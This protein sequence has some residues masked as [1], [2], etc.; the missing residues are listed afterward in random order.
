MINTRKIKKAYRTGKVTR[1]IITALVITAT[2]ATTIIITNRILELT[3]GYRLVKVNMDATQT[4]A[5]GVVDDC[6]TKSGEVVRID[7][8]NPLA[9]PDDWCI[10]GRGQTPLDLVNYK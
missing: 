3:A 7:H 8:T 5:E 9:S 10:N 2:I 1:G 4:F 6:F